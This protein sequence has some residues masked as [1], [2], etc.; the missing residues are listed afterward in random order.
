MRAAQPNRIDLYCHFLEKVCQCEADEP[1]V[2]ECKYEIM[3]VMLHGIES[4]EE[5]GICMDALSR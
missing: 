2:I 3:S 1:Q 5:R 4:I